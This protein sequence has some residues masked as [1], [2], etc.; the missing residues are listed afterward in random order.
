MNYDV[1]VWMMKAGQLEQER[2]LLLRFLD[3]QDQAKITDDEAEEYHQL[4]LQIQPLRE[5][6]RVER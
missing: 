4:W 3:L 1:A 6:V 2:N 5:R